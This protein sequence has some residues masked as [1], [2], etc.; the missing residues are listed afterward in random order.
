MAGEKLTG[1]L[2]MR[3]VYD[4]DTGSLKT[5][6]GATETQIELSADDGDSVITYPNN[7]VISDIG[8]D[9]SC[10]G[11]RSAQLYIEAGAASEA[12]IQVSPVDSGNIWMDLTGT[13]LSN[14][15]TNLKSSAIQTICARRI[16]V[17]VVSGTP[18]THLVMQAV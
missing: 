7:V 4:P 16:R 6:T 1:E 12:K 11:M 2:I 8:V 18:V 14:D 13:S 17:V 5:T 15:P 10:V 9:T 3:R